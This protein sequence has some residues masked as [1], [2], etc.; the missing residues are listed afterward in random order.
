MSPSALR[1]ESYHLTEPHPSVPRSNYIHA[2]RGGAG[3][4]AHYNP[5]EITAGPLATGPASRT[6][7]APPPTSA[8]LMGGRGGAGNV[9][10]PNERAI[11]SFDEELERQRKMLENAAPV[12]HIGR[13]GAGNAVDHWRPNGNRHGSAS[14]TLSSGSESSEKLRRGMDGAWKTLSRTFSRQ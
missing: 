14:S 8:R 11:F 6:K 12:Y 5:A 4:Y 3:N 13:G 9:Y 7:L 1:R 10:K 2:G